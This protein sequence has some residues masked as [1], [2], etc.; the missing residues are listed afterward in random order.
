[1]RTREIFARYIFDQPQIGS[2]YMISVTL[3]GKIKFSFEGVKIGQGLCFIPIQIH[4][5][6]IVINPSVQFLGAK[7]KIWFLTNSMYLILS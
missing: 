7:K 6:I 5:L 3:K 4:L 1:M 2:K